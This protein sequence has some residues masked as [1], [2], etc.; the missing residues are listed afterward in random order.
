MSR[1]TSLLAVPL[2]GCKDVKLSFPLS[3]CPGQCEA[4]PGSLLSAQGCLLPVAFE[5]HPQPEPPAPGP[6]ALTKTAVYRN[7]VL[8]PLVSVFP[9]AE[10]SQLV[11]VFWLLVDESF[12]Y[13]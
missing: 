7:D 11:I 10:P 5:T 13:I 4:P 1:R 6:L 3:H 2:Q 8:S 12:V 9:C